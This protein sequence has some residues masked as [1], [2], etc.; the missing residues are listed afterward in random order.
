VVLHQSRVNDAAGGGDSTWDANAAFG[1]LQ[2]GGEDVA[3]VDAGGT[4][5][6][7]D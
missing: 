5:D 6:G 1:F 7:L 3:W 2:Y 4:R